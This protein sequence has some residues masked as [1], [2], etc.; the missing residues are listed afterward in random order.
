MGDTEEAMRFRERAEWVGELCRKA[1]G[2]K[3]AVDHLLSL[4]AGS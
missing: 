4:A 3:T 1:G 2:R